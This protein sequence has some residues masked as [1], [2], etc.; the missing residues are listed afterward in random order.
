MRLGHYFKQTRLHKAFEIPVP[1]AP[2]QPSK[3]KMSALVHMLF[4]FDNNGILH[5]AL[6]KSLSGDVR[7]EIADFV[8]DTLMR[9]YNPVRMQQL[10]DEDLA[11][12]SPANNESVDGYRERLV[13]YL[14]SFKNDE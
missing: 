14:K 7:P 3:D 9:P 1:C 6:G 11:E 5:D 2:Q 10:S 8:R 12:L 4:S 13:S